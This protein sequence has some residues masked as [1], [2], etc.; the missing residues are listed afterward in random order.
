VSHSWHPERFS[1]L[2]RR[3]IR[4][5]DAGEFVFNLIR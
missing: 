3:Y 1:N 4:Q 2:Q 5:T